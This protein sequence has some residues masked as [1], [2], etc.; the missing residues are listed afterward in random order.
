MKK[1]SAKTLVAYFAMQNGL[2]SDV[3]DAVDEL[4]AELAKEEQR[5]ADKTNAYDTAWE[6]VRELLSKSNKP[7]SAAVIAERAKLP[8]GFGKGKV[9]YGLSHDWAERV[10]KIDGK[11]YEYTLKE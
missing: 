3:A 2:P 6:A 9:V 8:E 10:N 7:L 1:S 5:K 4:K 11:V